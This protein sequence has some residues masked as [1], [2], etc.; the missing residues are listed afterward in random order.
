MPRRSPGVLAPLSALAGALMAVSLPF[1]F[2]WRQAHD[3]KPELFA[4]VMAVVGLLAVVVAV[5]VGVGRRVRFAVLTFCALTATASAATTMAAMSPAFIAEGRVTAM[6]V[7]PGFLL[8][9]MVG[10]AGDAGA[11]AAGVRSASVTRLLALSL[12]VVGSWLVAWRAPVV[13]FVDP[14]RVDAVYP[15]HGAW[16]S[17]L[18]GLAGGLV[19]RPVRRQ[20]GS[21]VATVPLVAAAIVG[22]STQAWFGVAIAAVGISATL[23]PAREEAEKT[24]SQANHLV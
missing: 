13:Q 14:F 4:A 11:R 2:L 6:L 18:A 20:W 10:S 15:I 5:A 3:I 24:L 19:A 22:H 23:A 16:Y 21:L 12:L 9:A 1:A 8:A 7:A 17:L